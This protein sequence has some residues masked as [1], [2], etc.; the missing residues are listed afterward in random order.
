MPSDSFF[1]EQ[2]LRDLDPDQLHEMAASWA[3]ARS[4]RGIYLHFSSLCRGDGLALMGW[5]TPFMGGVFLPGG[6]L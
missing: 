2:A 6:R 3:R 4:A 5:W 1:A